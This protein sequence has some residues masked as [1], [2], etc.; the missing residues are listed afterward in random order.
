MG[1]KALCDGLKKG[2]FP[3]AKV[4]SVG[5]TGRTTYLILRPAYEEWA[6]K[7]IGPVINN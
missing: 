5:E 4:L 3:F 1:N 7:N 6:E 2:L